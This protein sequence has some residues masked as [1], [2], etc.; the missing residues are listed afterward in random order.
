MALRT[1]CLTLAAVLCAA[2][3]LHAAPAD[4]GK[5]AKQAAPPAPQARGDLLNAVDEIVQ[6]VSALRGLKVKRPIKR[7]VLSR[8]EISQKLKERIN[9]EYTPAEVRIEESILKRLGL[10]PEKAEYEKMLFDLLS[11]QVAGFYD[12]SAQTLYI[13]DWLPMD[14]QRPALAHEIEHALQDQHFD[15]RPFSQPLKEESD[16]QLARA[17]LVEGDGTA[18]MLEFVARSLGLDVSRLPE[19]VSSLGKQMMQLTVGQTPSFQRAPAVLRDTLIFPYAV[20]L[21]FVESIRIPHGWPR[22]DQVFARPPVSTEQVM[23]PTKYTQDEQPVRITPAAPTLAALP[24]YKEVRR[25]V[26]GEMLLKVWFRNKSTEEAAERAAAGW[27][28]DRLVALAPPPAPDEGEGRQV[29]L[30]L[31]SAWDTEGDAR[32]AERAA[33]QAITAALRAGAEANHVERRGS[34]VLVL[35]GVPQGAVRAAADEVL[36]TW[37]VESPAP[38]TRPQAPASGA[39]RG[40]GRGRGPTSAPRPAP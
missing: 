22:I 33:R 13:A 26:F 23:H 14:L 32:E 9:K 18:V 16:R 24:G 11:E 20:G 6:Q 8:E 37:R 38:G 19:M 2:A 1:L 15:L 28:G 29:A 40:P 27:G 34:L 4:T 3:P 10:L 39:Q 25:D 35:C 12:P 31:L 17:A 30:V 7:G 21:D 36:R 5:P